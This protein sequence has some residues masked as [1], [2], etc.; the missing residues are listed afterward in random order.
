MFSLVLL[1]TWGGILL[2]LFAVVQSAQAVCSSA[3]KDESSANKLVNLSLQDLFDIKI[4]IAS[5]IPES[6][7]EAPSSVTVFTHR[8]LLN[9]GVHSVEELLNFVPGFIASREII[10]GQGYMVAARGRT[11]PQASYNVLFMIDGQR[12]NNEKSGGALSFLHFLPLSN[13]KQIE[14]IR[15][16]GSALY[17]TSAFSG[18][19]NIITNDNDQRL[20]VG[21]GNEGGREIH[22][23]LSQ[24]WQDGHISVFAR[25]FESSGQS[26]ANALTAA[27]ETI[28]DP[29]QGGD[30][31]LKLCHQQLQLGLRHMRRDTRGFYSSNHA[32]E[33]NRNISEQ[34][35]FYAQYALWKAKQGKLT[36]R[37]SYSRMALLAHQVIA[38]AATMATLNT[39]APSPVSYLNSIELKEAEWSIQLDGH[40]QYQ[41]HTLFAGLEWRKPS[42]LSDAHWSNYNDAEA[43]AALRGNNRQAV[44]YYEAQDNLT[45]LTRTK[46]NRQILGL[47]LQDK[48]RI[49]TRLNTTLGVRYDYYSDFGGTLNPRL[50]LI[51]QARPKHYLKLMYGEAFRAP[52]IRQIAAFNAGNPKLEAE[53]VRTTELAWLFDNKNLQTSVN[54]FYSR[55]SQ[56]IDT[57]LIN[58]LGDRRFINL[59]DTL[60]NTGLEFSMAAQWN[61]GWSLRA[62]YTYLTKMEQNPTRFPRQTFSAIANYHWRDW[63][64]NLSAYYRATVEQRTLT[65]IIELSDYWLAHAKI[66]YQFDKNVT[67]VA[68]TEN[69]FNKQYLSSTKLPTLSGVPNRG[70]TYLF[71]LEFNF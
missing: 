61:N 49:N 36:A 46:P 7:L 71:G 32:G 3:L 18:V 63:N 12:L 38:D 27:P 19:V 15:G 48:Y 20:F 59:Q 6:V 8:E 65:E 26:Y 69:L 62:T 28:K 2:L 47:Y 11:T 17:G 22:S 42:A 16:P 34:T 14:I 5:K 4:D 10:F 29:Y 64:F 41:Q 43:L 24:R 25:Y 23:S 31:N 67:L 58:N 45:P 39:T 44:T 56:L 21:A 1:P 66:R 35:A 37:F 33:D 50:A 60:I 52:S 68:Q 57:R 9:I 30:F 54:Y 13:I 53:Q 70:R 40:Y 51:Y 55:Y